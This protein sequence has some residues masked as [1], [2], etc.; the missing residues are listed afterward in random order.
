MTTFAS[1]TAAPGGTTKLICFSALPT[2]YRPAAPPFTETETPLSSI[3][4]AGERNVSEAQMFDG[5]GHAKAFDGA[6]AML[7]R[8]MVNSPGATP[9]GAPGAGL[10]TGVGLGAGLGS[11]VAAATGM[12]LAPVKNES[13]AADCAVACGLN[14]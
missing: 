1:P 8:T 11:G 14:R 7:D 12:L 6:S 4:S 5:V 9:I 10:G 3:G 2:K 13:V